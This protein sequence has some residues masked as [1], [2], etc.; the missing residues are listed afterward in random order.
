MKLHHTRTARRRFRPAVETLE[1]RLVP[2]VFA[3]T[4]LADSNTAGRGALRAAISASNA[5]PGPNEIDILIP[6]T[7]QLTLNGTATDNSAGELSILNHSVTIV[8]QSG[9]IVVI[10]AGGLTTP[11]RV[12][13]ISPTG[14]AIEVSITG[15]IIQGGNTTTN[16]GGGIRALQGSSLTLN[17]DIIRNNKSFFDGGGIYT[18]GVVTLNGTAVRAN[19]TKLNGGGIATVGGSIV[20]QNNSVIAGN[21]AALNGGGLFERTA[22]SI[23]VTDSSVTDNQAAG[24]G[25]GIDGD[26]GDLTVTHS[27]VLRNSQ[28]GT[29]DT[30]GGGGIAWNS[31]GTLTITNSLFSGN[32]SADATPGHGGGAIA[33]AG[34]GRA[35][36]TGC[37]ITSNTAAAD[38]AGLLDSGKVVLDLLSSTL[39]G[40]LAGGYGGGVSLE[41]VG[42]SALS[43]VTLSGNT[44]G[45]G[46][47]LSN[48]GAATAY[49][50]DD[51]I[52][53]NFATT[54]GG[55]FSAAT[56]LEFY[57]TIVAK[58]S[59]GAG[60]DPDV[61][62]NTSAADLLDRG[63][64]FIGD[65]TGAADS[66]PPGTDN[67]HG[68]F[69]GTAGAP[70]DPLLDPLAD[71]GG[72]AVLPDGSHPLTHQNEA[73]S[74]NNGVRDRGPTLV[75]GGGG[76]TDE[77]GFPRLIDRAE[78]TGA[79]EFQDADLAV[80]VSA[81]A[82]P[83]PAGQPLT[84]TL[85]VTNRGPN[86]SH[87]V[88]L[89]DTLPPG[90]VVVSASAGY[91]VYS[92]S[93]SHGS[94]TGPQVVAFAALDLASGASTSITLTVNPAGPGS[95]TTT[96]A[97]STHDDP[98]PANNTA[99]L[100][101]T[102]LP[103]S[104]PAAAS[105]DVTPLVQV[106]PLG[107]RRRPQRQLAF[108][109]TNISGT[110]IQGPLAVVVPGTRPRRGPR[111]L[112]ADGETA[113]GQRFVRVD[114][115]GDA[116]LDAGQSTVVVLVFSQPFTP[117]GLVVLAGAFA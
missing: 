62:N 42:G 81:P 38:G 5:T 48:T 13:D 41:S 108:L 109:L 54:A 25:G 21:S 52:A 12:L 71:N 100:T 80:S 22:G 89:T 102:V 67:A 96:A 34:A 65:D 92:L 33:T 63:K 24:D 91:T 3:V 27:S 72:T 117:P 94:T 31:S 47:G 50:T 53:F 74:G 1:E 111:L 39:D 78:D 83:V 17:N 35:T 61:D 97:A 75:R 112:N 104:A 116:I 98:N 32:T 58:N 8:N 70:L 46:G 6:G 107:R 85:T 64:N 4:S 15:V 9:G 76:A 79:F 87:D 77:R 19:T 43:D 68:S 115:G 73:N 57:N 26:G 55:V 110:P 59:A 23:T 60:G 101:L 69:A 11:E 51:T 2:A 99:T 86:A 90:T 29:A 36:V 14:T 105:G 44:A 84:L 7:Y 40:N 16:A 95:F 66:F 106:M 49:L 103:P 113:D 93:S 30:L 45:T 114:V 37:E 82:G 56:A 10:D 88:K 28:T 20:V 18:N